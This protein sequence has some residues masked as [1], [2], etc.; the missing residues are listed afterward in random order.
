MAIGKGGSSQNQS[1]ISSGTSSGTTTTDMTGTQTGM[2]SGTQ[3]GSQTVDPTQLWTQG[4]NNLFSQLLGGGLTWDQQQ[5]VDRSNQGVATNQTGQNLDYANRLLGGYVGQPAHQTQAASVAD[6]AG[7]A[8][9]TGSSFSSLYQDPWQQDVVN[10]TAGDLTQGLKTGLNE[11]RASYGGALGNGREGVAAGTAVDDYVRT[12]GS[13][14]GGLRSEGFKVGTAAGQ[15]DAGRSLQ[16][17]QGNQQADLQ[18]ALA[19][20]EFRQDAGKFNALSKF[21]NDQQSIGAINQFGANSLNADQA[22]RSANQDIYNMSGGGFQ[23]L[24]GALGSQTPAFGQS[25]TGSQSGT[26]SGTQTSNS[27]TDFINAMSGRSSGSGSGKN[28]GISIG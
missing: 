22:S 18:A 27:V 11:I 15:S 21:Q 6:V 12:L 9:P 5:A 20:A 28:G 16:A 24:L 2:Q 8:A 10:A 19:D 17:L 4:S 14:L 13:T 26:S 3:S 1:G 7:T 23:Q 25:N